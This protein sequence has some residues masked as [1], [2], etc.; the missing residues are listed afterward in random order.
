MRL[1][2]SAINF[3]VLHVMFIFLLICRGLKHTNL[4]LQNAAGK[5]RRRVNGDEGRPQVQ[6]A[7]DARV[8]ARGERGERWAEAS[9]QPGHGQ[10]LLRQG[11]GCH[12][13]HAGESGKTLICL[14]MYYFATCN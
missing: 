2:V 11:G 3:I 8:H 7:A 14:E 10:W 6:E 1:N 12:V 9:G 4:E 5:P 13:H